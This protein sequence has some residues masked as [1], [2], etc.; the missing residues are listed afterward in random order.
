M[1]DDGKETGQATVSRWLTGNSPVEPAVLCWLRELLRAQFRQHARSP[2]SWGSKKS[3]L[4]GV[5]NFKGGVGTSTIAA[6][7]AIIAGRE[8]RQPTQHVRV[9][10]HDDEI[11]GTLR[12]VGISSECVGVGE[13]GARVPKPGEIMIVDI[14]RNVSDDFFTAMA[15]QRPSFDL[16]VVPAD[17]G[18]GAEISGTDKFLKRLPDVSKVVFL[19]YPRHRVDL[20]YVPLASKRGFD[21]FSEQFVPFAL[22]R[23]LDNEIFPAG[24]VGEWQNEDQFFLF[25][26]LFENLVSRLGMEIREMGAAIRAIDEMSLEGLLGASGHRQMA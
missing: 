4:I 24:L 19:H 8:L 2:L 23:S 17:F 20:R 7:L 10:S 25:W 13:L 26:D 5:G 16:V 21:V 18:S 12:T 3:L 15:A 11:A 1:R 9:Q 6:A 14:P 22:P